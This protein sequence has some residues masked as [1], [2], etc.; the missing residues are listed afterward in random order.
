MNNRYSL[1]TFD[2]Y[3]ALFDIE[4]SL[5]PLI[6]EIL[7][8][9]GLNFVRTW[10]RKQLEYVLISNSLGQDRL[11]FAMITR[12][13]LD[14]TLARSS[15]DLSDSAK[16]TLL[17]RW[18]DLEPWSE[19]PSVLEALKS[20]GYTMAL[21]SNGDMTQLQT[22]AQ[23]LP[24]VFDHIFS[25]EQAGYYKPHPSVYALPLDELKLK[26][27]Q[28]LHVAGSPMDALGTKAAGLHC[29][30]SNRKHEPLL[31]AT[32]SVDYDMPDLNQLLEIL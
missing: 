18:L 7:N 29:A 22:L 32:Y 4:S 26:A 2:V 15:L 31:D 21:L 25:S 16:T 20:R 24:P 1:I 3:T 13:A 14:D 11:S 5:T 12:R 27:D 19:V 30:W 6:S 17:A 9:N 8:I 28:I 23:K 10:R